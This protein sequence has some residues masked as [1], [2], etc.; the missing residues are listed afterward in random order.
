[1][2]QIASKCVFLQIKKYKNFERHCLLTILIMRH[3]VA[4]ML[5]LF[6]MNDIFFSIF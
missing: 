5:N 3:Y 1:M 4:Q 2:A 6:F